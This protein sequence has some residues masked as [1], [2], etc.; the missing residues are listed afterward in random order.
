MSIIVAYLLDSNFNSYFQESQNFFDNL[1]FI[2]AVFL[3]SSVSQ[4]GDLI[5]SFFKRAS[6]IKDTGNIFP[7]H[8]GLLD[9]IDGMIFAF[10]FVFIAEKIL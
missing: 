9:R 2:L 10:A 7:G 8:G 5:I 6:N 3:V 1:Y 4:I